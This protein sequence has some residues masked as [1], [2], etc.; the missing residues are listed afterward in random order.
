MYVHVNNT[1]KKNITYFYC[2]TDMLQWSI[3][4]YT[5]CIFSLTALSRRVLLETNSNHRPGSEAYSNILTLF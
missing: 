3:I 2:V 4:V 5:T 1:L